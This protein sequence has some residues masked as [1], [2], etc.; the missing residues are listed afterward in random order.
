[1]TTSPVTAGAS[2]C[3]A[4]AFDVS[5]A[6]SI[7]RM[8]PRGGAGNSCDS[9]CS[10]STSALAFTVAPGVTLSNC[11]RPASSVFTVQH[12]VADAQFDRMVRDVVGQLAADQREPR[13]PVRQVVTGRGMPDICFGSGIGT[14]RWMLAHRTEDTKATE[15]TEEASANHRSA[16]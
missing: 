9:R 5:V 12:L 11:A 15:D 2:G 7:S 4:G 16:A 1:M 10:P 3:V 14:A 6:T 8:P 13:S